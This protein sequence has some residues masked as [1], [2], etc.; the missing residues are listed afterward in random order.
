MRTLVCI[1]AATAMITADAK[2]AQFNGSYTLDGGQVIEFMAEGTVQGDLD[3]VTI[4]SFLT[5]PTFD[6]IAPLVKG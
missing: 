1:V 6:G 3:T 5:T 2:A 4:D